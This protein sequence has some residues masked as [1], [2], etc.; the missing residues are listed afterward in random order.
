MLYVKDIYLSGRSMKVKNGERT[1]FWGDTWCGSTPRKDQFPLLFNICNEFD[2]SM[3][4]AAGRGWLF[5]YRRWL[6]ADLLIQDTKLRERVE[7]I[8]LVPEDDIPVWDWTKNGQFAVK[9]VYK[10]ISNSGIERSFKHLWKS[11]IPLKIKVWLWLI[12]HNAIATKNIMSERGW[13]WNTQ[14]Q[15]CDQTENI[16]HLFFTCP[17]AKYVWSCVAKSVGAQNRPGNFSQFF[18]W[19]PRYVPTSR[20]V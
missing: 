4:E 20:N 12:W 6:S 13:V 7:S 10:D 14:C 8:S 11:K 17:T 19:F 1:H 18:G 16:H 9:S 3:V 2:I 15:F 5:T